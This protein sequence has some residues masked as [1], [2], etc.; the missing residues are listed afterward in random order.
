MSLYQLNGEEWMFLRMLFIAV[1][2]E[3][4]DYLKVYL[5]E[6]A[7]SQSVRA[8]LSSLKEK[9]IIAKGYKIPNEGEK[10]EVTDVEFDTR[11]IT[12]MFKASNAAGVE[13]M[14]AYPAYMTTAG[15]TLLNLRNI[16]SKGGYIDEDDFYFAYGKKIKFSP[17]THK[18]VLKTLKF[19]SDND[20]IKYSI[21]EFVGTSKWIELRETMHKDQMG[22]FLKKMDTHEVL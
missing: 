22:K 12:K 7:K 19:G 13:L 16:V 18:E 21:V 11:F 2:E 5:F 20:L 3:K 1:E 17:I 8:L 14:R 10:F 4:L 6:C 9:K 15:G